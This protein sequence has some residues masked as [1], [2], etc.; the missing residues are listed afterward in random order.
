MVAAAVFANPGCKGGNVHAG[1]ASVFRQSVRRGRRKK[2]TA[3]RFAGIPILRIGERGGIEEKLDGIAFP[4]GV[5]FPG[6]AFRVV[7][8]DGKGETVRSGA[9]A[10]GE[11][12]SSAVF[13]LPDELPLK[14]GEGKSEVP[15]AVGKID[16]RFPRTGQF[17]IREAEKSTSVEFQIRM[18]RCFGKI[19]TDHG[20]DLFRR[21]ILDLQEQNRLSVFQNRMGGEDAEGAF[22]GQFRLFQNGLEVFPAQELRVFGKGKVAGGGQGIQVHVKTLVIARGEVE[23]EVLGIGSFPEGGKLPSVMHAVEIAGC[24]G[25]PVE[26]FQSFPSVQQVRGDALTGVEI[27][28]DVTGMDHS[29]AEFPVGGEFVLEKLVVV[30]RHAPIDPFSE[31]DQRAAEQMLRMRGRPRILLARSYEEAMGIYS[32][33]KNNMLGVITD[34]SFPKDGE[35]DHTVYFTLQKGEDD[36]VPVICNVFNTFGR[37]PGSDNS[38]RVTFDIRTVDGRNETREFDITDLFSTEAALEHNWLLLEETITIDPPA[39][40]EPGEGGGFQP[41]VGDWDDEDHEIVI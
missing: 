25:G 34:V 18:L 2:K 33:Y 3:D 17:S 16:D 19:R 26:A 22:S 1:G 28:G 31:V 12:R 15:V 37:I 41:G 5:G 32:K 13:S 35:K 6:A 27:V 24:S 8:G 11:E 20:A 14:G 21:K 7:H 30:D 39:P 4:G 10:E 23:R 40:P 38:L 9:G 29:V 36:G